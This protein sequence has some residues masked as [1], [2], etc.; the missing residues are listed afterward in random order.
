[1]EFMKAYLGNLLK[2]GL[3]V[4]GVLIF[5]KV[6]YPDSLSFLSGTGQVYAGLGWW[7]VIILGLLLLALPRRAAR[8]KEIGRDFWK[9]YLGNLLKVGL[10]VVGTVIFLKVLYPDSLSLLAGTSQ[11]FAGLA[12]WPFIVLGLLLFA[13]PRRKRGRRR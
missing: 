1:M 11:V 8:K 6:L 4:V 5:L 10:V 12:I 13:L 3:V 2:I 7:P 9:E